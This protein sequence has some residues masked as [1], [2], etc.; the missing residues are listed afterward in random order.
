M[1]TTAEVW[2]AAPLQQLQSKSAGLRTRFTISTFA[3]RARLEDG[4]PS[5]EP[6]TT[7]KSDRANSLI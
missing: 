2:S 5:I 6:G 1:G 4:T 7:L 3:S